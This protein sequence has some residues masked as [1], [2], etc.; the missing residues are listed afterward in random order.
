[1]ETLSQME[2][3]QDYDITNLSTLRVKA[4]VSYFVEPETIEELILA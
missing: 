4:K 1:M 3:L 2:I